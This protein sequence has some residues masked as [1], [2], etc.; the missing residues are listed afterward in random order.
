MRSFRIDVKTETLI[1]GWNDRIQRRE[2]RIER[3][4]DGNYYLYRFPSEGPPERFS[5][6]PPAITALSLYLSELETE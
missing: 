4:D 1:I 5:S 2:G 6:L 3:W